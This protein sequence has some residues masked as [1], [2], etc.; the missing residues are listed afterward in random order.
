MGIFSHDSTIGPHTIP[1]RATPHW[2]FGKSQG[3][4]AGAWG[5]RTAELIL[6]PA[7]WERERSGL[8]DQDPPPPP[9]RGG[10]REPTSPSYP[11]TST[12]ALLTPH[13]NK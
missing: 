12:P 2:T 10:R 11:L 3:Q 13:N 5:Q 8:S 4:R 1:V 9:P 6:E 7:R